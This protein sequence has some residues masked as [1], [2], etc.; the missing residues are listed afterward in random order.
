[1]SRIQRLGIGNGGMDCEISY[2]Q[3][4]K[5]PNSG[6]IVKPVQGVSNR[7]L[8]RNPYNTLN[9]PIANSGSRPERITTDN[10][11]NV[12]ARSETNLIPGVTNNTLLKN[13]NNI[14]SIAVGEK[15]A[16]SLQ[17]IKDINNKLLPSYLTENKG[18]NEVM[19][20]I[21]TMIEDKPVKLITIQLL[22]ILITKNVSALQDKN[23][24]KML[25]ALNAFDLCLTEGRRTFRENTLSPTSIPEK[26][27]PAVDR[28]VA[29]IKQ[30]YGNLVA[31]PQTDA[32]IQTGLSE[33]GLLSNALTRMFEY[34]NA[35]DPSNT[36]TRDQINAAAYTGWGNQPVGPQPVGPQPVGPQPVGP[37]SVGPQS[38]GPQ[39]VG[40]LQPTGT[41]Q[42]TIPPT[43]G[44]AVQPALLS[45]TFSDMI[46][47]FYDEV[48]QEV[49]YFNS[50]LQAIPPFNI[51]IYQRTL[52]NA[53]NGYQEYFDNVANEQLQDAS[54]SVKQ[55]NEIRNAF[56]VVINSQHY[57]DLK[58]RIYDLQGAQGPPPLDPG[59]VE[60]NAP[61]QFVRP[62]PTNPDLG[63]Q[64][65][66]PQ[67]AGPQQAGPQQAG[68]LQA[69][70]ERPLLLS[71]PSVLKY[72]V[73]SKA[74]KDFL[75]KEVY[76]KKYPLMGYIFLKLSVIERS[77]RIDKNKDISN[78]LNE[79][80]NYVNGKEDEFNDELDTYQKNHG[81][82][83]DAIIKAL[84]DIR[85]FFFQRLVGF[86]R[87]SRR[88]QNNKVVFQVGK[89]TQYR[90]Y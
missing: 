21:L 79:I 11:G 36:L 57:A 55:L 59:D 66:G 39:S 86:G 22:K 87:R 81:N 62:P 45:N 82:K 7:T 24:Q 68:P 56:F 5:Y 35:I 38:V 69:K 25:D 26:I 32:D 4:K 20:Q 71:D 85:S 18:V 67:Q 34:N 3:G 50:L 43:P 84:G 76:T 44:L 52:E 41:P 63:P 53:V 72:F 16:L 13:P 49:T 9:E 27:R 1:M 19:L 46:K 58:Q 77:L 23:Q 29:R 83:F 12:F 64:Q 54:L 60:Q 8:L 2:M 88:P 40:P 10:R 37:Q 61:P 42:P 30:I 33:L 89:A 80:T 74:V 90:K 48:E 78:E 75:Q 6:D 65:A 70:K 51:Q 15:R 28:Y 47:E 31:T 17:R 73:D 14:K